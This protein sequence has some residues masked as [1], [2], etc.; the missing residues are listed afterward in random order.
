MQPCTIATGG[1][2]YFSALGLKL[3][4]AKNRTMRRAILLLLN[5]L[6]FAGCSIAPYVGDW[7]T[8]RQRVSPGQVMEDGQ[9]GDAARAPATKHDLRRGKIQTPTAR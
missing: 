1:L 2:H 8:P 3:L 6:A 7:S 5:L 4:S 9:S